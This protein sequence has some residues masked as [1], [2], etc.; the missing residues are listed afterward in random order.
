MSYNW[1]QSD[2]PD[3]KYD[4]S[5]AQDALFTFAEKTGQVSGIIKSLPD[6][7]QTDTIIDLMVSEA[8]KTSEIEGEYLSRSDVMSSIRHNLGLDTDTTPTADRRAKGAADLMVDVRNSY[9]E[10]LTTEKLFQWHEMLLGGQRRKIDVGMWRT[11]EEPMQVISGPIGKWKIHFEA[12]ASDKV[13]EEMARFI[14]WFNNTSPEGKEAIK[15]PVLR[16][17][18]AHLYFESIHPFEDGNGRIG[19]A[20]AEKTLSQGLGRPVLL[21]LSETIEAKKKD[22]YKALQSAQKTNEIT[23]W[24]IYFSNVVLEAQTRAEKNIDFILN[25]TKLFD[26]F[27]DQLNDRHLKVIRRM[28]DAGLNGFEGGMSAKKYVAIT[29]TSTATA[30]R[31][32]KFLSDIGMLKQIGGGRSTK[33]EINF[34]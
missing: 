23:N 27:K 19:R 1:Q 14:D 24:I 25:K 15:N 7:I 6:N 5:V 10:P 21:S 12:P 34:R 32:L 13:S 33:Y 9:Q 4:V 2:W 18:I 31:D 8:I 30:T 29:K 17:A 11:H 20:I 28:L 26:R 22:Y 16:S 3:F